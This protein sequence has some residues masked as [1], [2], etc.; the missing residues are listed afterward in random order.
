MHKSELVAHLVSIFAEE[1][2]G[3]AAEL[4][5]GLI[6]YVVGAHMWLNSVN[7]VTT[8]AS[9]EARAALEVIQHSLD[10]AAHDARNLINEL[11]LCREAVSQH[12]PCV[13]QIVDYWRRR[14]MRVE[15]HASADL[16]INGTIAAILALTL[17]WL[18]KDAALAAQADTVRLQISAGNPLVVEFELH[19]P[20]TVTAASAAPTQRLAFVKSLVQLLD[21][22]F[23]I[24]S[25]SSRKTVTIRLPVEG[26]AHH[27]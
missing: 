20:T 13:E 5:D 4:H 27:A 12:E 1:R 26:I 8:T 24:D 3:V 22:Q 17:T 6:Q 19:R 16:Q 2:A 15:H 18:F 7:T 10:R 21:G 23:E 11:S 25:S 9:P 14:G